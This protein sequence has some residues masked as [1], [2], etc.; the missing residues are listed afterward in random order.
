MQKIGISLLYYIYYLLH[1][2]WIVL[3]PNPMSEKKVIKVTYGEMN[4]KNINML[5]KIN[6]EVFPVKYSTPF[7]QKVAY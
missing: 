2:D 4:P 1:S 5:R 7:Y 6:F 3:N